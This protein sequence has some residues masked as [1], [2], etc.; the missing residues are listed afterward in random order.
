MVLVA[1]GGGGGRAQRT[2]FGEKMRKRRTTGLYWVKL[3]RLNSNENENGGRT[4]IWEGPREHGTDMGDQRV[5]N[6]KRLGSRVA[7][8]GHSD[9]EFG[10]QSESLTGRREGETGD[11]ERLL[12]TPFVQE[13]VVYFKMGEKNPVEKLGGGEG[14][15]KRKLKGVGRRPSR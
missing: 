7:W 15:G 1:G 10:H 9:G 2:R 11:S 3:G 6:L 4:A 14:G 12:A 5:K 13:L 8:R